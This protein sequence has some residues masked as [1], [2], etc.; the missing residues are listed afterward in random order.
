[1]LAQSLLCGK[2]NFAMMKVSMIL[3]KD[4]SVFF[5]LLSKI[6][7]FV[8]FIFNDKNEAISLAIK[9]VLNILK[10]CAKSL[11]VKQVI[12]TSSAG[13]VYVEKCQK[14]IY[15]QNCWSDVDFCKRLRRW[16]DG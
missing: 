16:L 9:G 12:Y 13:A 10:S 6:L 3:F 2:P 5:M 11:T 8:F 14:L 4:V 7:R 15:D 1:M